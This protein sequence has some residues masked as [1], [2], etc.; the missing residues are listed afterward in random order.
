MKRVVVL[1]LL[2]SCIAF[3][4]PYWERED[5]ERAQALPKGR[6]VMQHETGFLRGNW[7]TWSYIHELCQT[8]AFIS[9]MQVSDSLDPEFGGL[10]EGEDPPNTD[11]VETDNTQEAIWVW[12]RHHEITGD[13][14]YFVNIRRAWIYVMNFPAY[15]EEG[16]GTDYY[17]VWNCGLALYAESKY[18]DIF[19]DTTYSW[20]ADTCAK[21][22]LE[23]PL[24]FTVPDPIY[25]RLHPKATSFAAGMLY[26]YGKEMSNQT[27]MDT[28]LAYGHRVREW[29]ES[30]TSTNINDEVW[31]MSGGTC[32]WGLCRSIFD[33]DTIFGMSWLN[34]CLPYMK[35][36]QPTGNWNNSWNIWYA[37][38][39]NFSA[40]I[41]HDNSYAEY[42][43]SLTDSLLVQDYGD[44]GGVPP[45][46]TLGEDYDHSWI[47]SYMVFMGFEGLMDSIKNYDA[48]VNDIVATGPRPFFI[49]GDTIELSIKVANYGYSPLSNVYYAIDGL[50]YSADTTVDLGIGEENTIGFAA[51]WIPQDT[52]YFDFTAY[53][54]YVGDERNENDTFDVSLFVRPLRL[55]AGSIVDTTTGSG[56]YAKL[57]FQFA[58]DT[59][60]VYFDSTETDSS[61]GNFSIYLIDSLY[62]AYI[63]TDIPYPDFVEGNIYVTP[64]S[65]STL[66][67]YL[68]PADILVIN[69]DSEAR[70][71]EYYEKPLDTLNMTYKVWAPVNQGLFPMSRIPEF[72][73]NTIIWYTG[74]AVT[75]NVTP[76]EQ[77]SLAVF[78]NSGGKLLITGQNIGEEISGTPFYSDY[79]HAQLIDDSIHTAYC[80]P[81]TTDSLGDK[82]GRLFTTGASGAVNQYSRDV[83]ASDDS[84]HEFLFYDE[85]M[86]EAS[87]IWYDDP[88][89]HYQL[90]Y[91]GFGIEAIHKRPGFM[92]RTELLTEI[93]EWFD[94]LAIKET[95]SSHLQPVFNVYPNPAHCKLTLY[96]HDAAFRGEVLI[97]IYDAAGRLIKELV[98]NKPLNTMIWDLHDSLG[99]RVSS[100]IYFIRLVI[101]TKEEIIK[102]V[103]LR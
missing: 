86:T 26:Q 71:A 73:L 89:S 68:Y 54:A 48:G 12:C 102:A 27:Y 44:D 56:I 93:L 80:Y 24:S 83:I 22:I 32:V 77:E 58:D 98:H 20:Y 15:H 47:S 92:S 37:N 40:R 8:A 67:F 84:S 43:H 21:Y 7:Q 95:E 30:D 13:T 97:G 96:L 103:V 46:S 51:P 5:F 33:A 74:M 11:I 70:Y 3:S 53:S 99:R 65:V 10:I 38:A 63:L 50:G 25:Q 41:T 31:A 79:L 9:S 28:A 88:V 36:A 59:G 55:V 23:H 16:T 2:I 1:T 78:L 90:I 57:Y 72:N 34:S 29:I 76:E 61:S 87:G 85:S 100:G 4:L 66:D 64:D 45:T 101:D 91:F 19:N 60:T 62:M 49:A 17:R 81:D 6:S 52:G 94:V 35:Y 75:D 42:H 39:Y 82:I 14:T 18:R 69:R